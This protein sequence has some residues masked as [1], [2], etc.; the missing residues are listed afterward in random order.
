[1]IFEKTL[2]C[3]NCNKKFESKVGENEDESKIVCYDCWVKDL[4]GRPKN[5]HKK[6]KRDFNYII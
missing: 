3:P 1:M 5:V 2:K 6:E 4:M